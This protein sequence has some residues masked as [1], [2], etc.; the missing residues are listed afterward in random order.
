MLLRE[1]IDVYFENHTKHVNG[2]CGK[3]CRDFDV[4]E[5]VKFLIVATVIYIHLS[6]CFKGIENNGNYI[7]HLLSL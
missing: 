4:K 6:P 2:I 1:I 5:Y 3:R 7:Y